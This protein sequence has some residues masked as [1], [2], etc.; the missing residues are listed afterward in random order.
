[1]ESSDVVYVGKGKGSRAWDITAHLSHCPELKHTLVTVELVESNMTESEALFC[2]NVLLRTHPRTFNRRGAATVEGRG[3]HK[4]KIVKKYTRE[5]LY[6]EVKSGELTID[7][8]VKNMRRSIGKNQNEFAEK[9]GLTINAL[10]LLENGKG[11]PTVKTLNKM[12]N[13]FGLEVGFK[14]K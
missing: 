7:Q 5:Q 14:F 1:V 11:N 2:E 4:T 9:F 12:A 10:S 3:L 8:G 13:A 6:E